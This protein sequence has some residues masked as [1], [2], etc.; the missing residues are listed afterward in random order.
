[1]PEWEDNKK[2]ACV[3]VDI[4]GCVDSLCI[5]HRVFMCGYIWCVCGLNGECMCSMHILV[6]IVCVSVIF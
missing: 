4:Y 1:M 3:C 6:S 5:V 2:V